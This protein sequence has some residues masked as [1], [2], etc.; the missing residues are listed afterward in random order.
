VTLMVKDLAG[1]SA[2]SSATVTIS[3]V[4]PEFPSVAAMAVLF[5]IV[6]SFSLALRKKQKL[7]NYVKN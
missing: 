4:I 3:V 2:A 5:A 1:N 6:S 7:G